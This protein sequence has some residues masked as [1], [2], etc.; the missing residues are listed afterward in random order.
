MRGFQTAGGHP[1]KKGVANGGPVRGPGTGTSDDVKKD[2]PNGTYIMPTDS[3]QAIGEENLAALGTKALPVALSN[4]E[5]ELP[6]EQVHAVGVQALEQ[7]RN[8]TH[9]P[10][11]PRGFVFGTAPAATAQQK[12]QQATGPRGFSPN[13]EQGMDGEPRMFFRHGGIADEEEQRKR[14]AAPVAPATPAAPAAQAPSWN[15]R[16]SFPANRNH[17]EMFTQ[18]AAQASTPNQPTAQP[19]ARTAPATQAQT[20][21][22]A[23]AAPQAPSWNERR[24]FPG[25]RNHPELFAQPS[26]APQTPNSATPAEPAPAVGSANWWLKPNPALENPNRQ[27][28]PTQ[29][30]ISERAS[31]NF[32][33][34][35]NDVRSAKSNAGAPASAPQTDW[36][37]T[38]PDAAQ[39]QDDR[40]TLGRG[41]DF[42]K[43]AWNRTGA[44]LADS[45][46]VIPRGL[47]G[48]YDTAVV[49]PM[50]AAGFDAGYISPALTPAGADPASMTPF[51]DI[52]VS[53]RQQSQAAALQNTPAVDPP[54][55]SGAEA[56][57]GRT[58][59]P[60]A[61]GREANHVLGL[62][63]LRP[64][65]DLPIPQ[66][67]Y[68]LRGGA[69]ARQEPEQA[70]A[71]VRQVAPG[72]YRSGNSYSDTE[73]GAI[74]GAGARREPSAQNMAA[75]DALAQRY[76][77]Q[78]RG[79]ILAQQQAQQQAQQATGPRGFV[80]GADP[81]AQRERRELIRSL[82]TV[83]PG[84]RGITAAQRQGMLQLQ[85]QEANQQQARDNNELSL[86]Q[87]QMQAG[88]Q[89]DI[90][91][92]KEEG[93]TGRA[94]MR[95][96]AETGRAGARNSL[97]EGRLD[98]DRGRLSLDRETR[99]FEIRQ[100]QRLEA[101]QDRLA[102]A[103][104]QEERTAIAQQIRELSGQQSSTA[105][106]L[107]DNVIVLGGGEDEAGR[108]L[109]QT[110]IDLRTM[111]P[112]NG[113]YAPAVP[114]SKEQL[115]T[116]QRYTTP[117]GTVQTWNG[118]VFI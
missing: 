27:Y 9:R 45:L 113:E 84:A 12:A 41:F 89:R 50:R 17:P 87:A 100:G 103:T 57:P 19:A 80:F 88:T 90:A 96:M 56:G 6:P 78:S 8:A 35:Q 112:I 44:A 117:D 81:A 82:T 25:N 106:R 76:D 101:L 23:A 99:G 61:I 24:S 40:Q 79:R 69:Q 115:V 47:A 32:K 66:Q 92:M 118:K 54:A 97:D 29:Q 108:K 109:P 58:L 75:A 67:G 65:P 60:A 71:D 55:P 73:Q 105:E 107:R 98:V 95:E 91:A 7:M 18:P 28:G 42:A 30:E 53:Q 93:D 63:G 111:Q 34:W 33:Q 77:Q 114:K 15:E 14:A 26:G 49:R 1:K 31:N 85:S 51:S 46:S 70:R 13:P 4:G 104:T 20:P 116:G 2:V 10:A 39:I 3:T 38:A 37:T 83:L 74:A 52:V 5:Y 59:D 36:R 94:F 68:Q 48:A 110:A 72:V 21:A 64:P 62:N 11:V 22:P 16:R 43:Q 102:Q 86:Q